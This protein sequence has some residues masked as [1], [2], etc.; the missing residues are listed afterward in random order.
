MPRL[1]RGVSNISCANESFISSS[2][3]SHG[4]LYSFN[5]VASEET[6]DVVIPWQKSRKFPCAQK[7]SYP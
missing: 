5:G 4:F 3:L 1:T 2:I 6:I 7:A